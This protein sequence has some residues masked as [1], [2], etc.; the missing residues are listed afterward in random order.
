MPVDSPE[1]AAAWRAA[2]IAPRMPRRPPPPPAPPPPSPAQQP[3]LALATSTAELLAAG[4]DVQPL[5]PAL[6]AA[7]AAV[8][9]AE[10][11]PLALPMPVWRL[12]TADVLALVPSDKQEGELSDADAEALG[13]FWFAAA[14]GEV[15]PI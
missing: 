9:A 11:S 8:P 6:R 14:A 4:A 15:R 13:P 12:L 1:A 10:R 3:V 2:N 5:V 7:L